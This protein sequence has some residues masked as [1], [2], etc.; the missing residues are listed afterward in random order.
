MTELLPTLT[1]LVVRHGRTALNIEERYLGVLD[2]P[3]DACGVAQASALAGALAGQAQAIVS[4]PRR[5]ALQTAEVLAAASGLPVRVLDAFAERDVGVFEGLTRDEARD[6]HPALW[7]QDVTRQWDGAPP[8]GESIRAVVDRVGRGLD[9][10]RR[11]YP[12][13]TV[14]LVAHG[15]VA[16]VVRALL[17]DLSWEDF[18]RYALQNGAF[19]RYVLAGDAPSSWRAA[20]AG[21]AAPGR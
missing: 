21:V 9:L 8:G 18:F 1:L 16:K 14:V 3:L 13:R 10:L 5:R 17:L 6:A 7:R 11:D 15:F 12:D 2:P 20:L 4:S 19:E